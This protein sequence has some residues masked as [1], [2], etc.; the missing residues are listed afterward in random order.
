M[1]QISADKRIV[2]PELS[3]QLME[4][5]FKVHNKLANQYV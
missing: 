2:Y 1:K 3:Y 5:L 4:T